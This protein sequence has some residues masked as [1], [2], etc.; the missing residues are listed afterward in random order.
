MKEFMLLLQ[1]LVWPIVLGLLLYWKREPLSRV[2][3]AL[4]NRI[5]EGAA[6]KAAGVEIAAAPSL[7]PVPKGEIDP[8]HVDGLPHD[9][10]IVHAARRDRTLDAPN[11]EYYRLR[12]FLEA[13]KPERLDDIAAV[14][15][16]LHP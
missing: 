10:Y 3:T 14:K 7:P 13:D 4:V 16:R 1:S 9:I 15:Y 12:I 11:R 2:I 8:R 6:I 5:E